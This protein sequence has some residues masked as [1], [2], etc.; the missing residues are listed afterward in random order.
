MTCSTTRGYTIGVLQ[1]NGA[2]CEDAVNILDKRD[3]VSEKKKASDAAFGL[4]AQLLAAQLNLSA[5]AE[6][7]Q[8]AVDAVNAGQTLLASANFDGTGTYWKGKNGGADKALA[9]SLA[10][11]LDEY[12]NGFLCP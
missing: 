1:L 4:A 5:G 7:C 10:A 9:N 8:E 12:N 3:I 2:D 11:T 6:T